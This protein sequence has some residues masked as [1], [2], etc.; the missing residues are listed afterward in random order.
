MKNTKHTPGPWNIITRPNSF[1]ISVMSEDHT[2]IGDVSSI[3]NARLIA[4][5]PELL[6]ALEELQHRF[7]VLGGCVFQP[8]DEP[9]MVKVT[10][11]LRKAKGE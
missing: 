7:Y 3:E 9:F 11:L 6:E 4:S 10:E 8:K 2:S 1:L 5:A